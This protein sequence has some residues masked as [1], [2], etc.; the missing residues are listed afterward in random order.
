MCYFICDRMLQSISMLAW[1][2]SVQ[3]A[4]AIYLARKYFG[5]T[6]SWV[7]LC[8]GSDAQNKAFEEF[9]GIKKSELIGC[10]SA[11]HSI[12]MK[13]NKLHACEN[14]YKGSR[15]NH[16]YNSIPHKTKCYVF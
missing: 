1:K 5:Y 10:A 11:I 3:A 9:T 14:K 8:G 4:A 2:P 6:D 7:G 12:I 13:P 16:I 15:F